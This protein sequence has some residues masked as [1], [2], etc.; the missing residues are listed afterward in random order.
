MPF[1]PPPF[2]LG[3][4]FSVTTSEELDAAAATSDEVVLNAVKSIRSQLADSTKLLAQAQALQ[5]KLVEK[6]EVM[7]RMV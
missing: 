1:P 7:Q 2:F 5:A 4:R 6:V 3:S